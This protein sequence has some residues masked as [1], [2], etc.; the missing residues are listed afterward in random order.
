MRTVNS[1][2]NANRK[3]ANSSGLV[4]CE[5]LRVV[6]RIGAILVAESISSDPRMKGGVEVGRLESEKFDTGVISASGEKEAGTYSQ[7]S[8]KAPGHVSLP[9]PVYRFARPRR[10][11]PPPRRLLRPPAGLRERAPGNRERG[12]KKRPGSGTRTRPR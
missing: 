5:C 2:L 11:P 4:V 9:L 1:S 8:K 7:T 12:G 10:P 3:R 6:A